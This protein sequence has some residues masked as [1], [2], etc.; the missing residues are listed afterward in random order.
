MVCQERC[1]MGSKFLTMCV[2]KSVMGSAVVVHTPLKFA[3]ATKHSFGDHSLSYFKLIF[4]DKNYSKYNISY[5]QI[6]NH[7]H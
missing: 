2:D 3:P 7:L 6:P 4:N 5:I 1:E